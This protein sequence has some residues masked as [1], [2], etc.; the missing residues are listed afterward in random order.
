MKSQDLEIAVQIRDTEVKLHKSGRR[1]TSRRINNVVRE[2]YTQELDFGDA[3][4]GSLIQLFICDWGVS[5]FAD[6]DRLPIV[7]SC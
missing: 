4:T 3:P 6:F 5:C 7:S 2:N 1:L